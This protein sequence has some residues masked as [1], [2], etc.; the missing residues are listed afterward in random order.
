MKKSLEYSSP[1]HIPADNKLDE[2]RV[3]DIN[4]NIETGIDSISKR[5]FTGEI[6]ITDSA[7]EMSKLTRESMEQ[8]TEE[9]ASLLG[10]KAS[11]LPF[12][13]FFI[14]FLF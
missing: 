11:E 4:K 7:L 8:I 13:I 3:L 10:V 2:T 5:V 6:S 14:W 1:D 9:F 12:A